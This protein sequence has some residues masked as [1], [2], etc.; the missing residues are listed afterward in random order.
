MDRN[1]LPAGPDHPCITAGINF[2]MDPLWCFSL[3]HRFNQKQ[4]DFNERQQK[5]NYITFHDFNYP[6]IIIAAAPAPT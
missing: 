5:T 3:S 1:N 4:D 6:G 2:F